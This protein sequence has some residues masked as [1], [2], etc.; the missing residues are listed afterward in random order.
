MF[1][2]FLLFQLI[3]ETEGIVMAA[4]LGWENA[5]ASYASKGGNMGTLREANALSA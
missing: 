2:L 5:P 3:L 1:P 4:D